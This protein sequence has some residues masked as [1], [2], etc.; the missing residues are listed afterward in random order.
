MADVRAV[1]E[2]RFAA[3]YETVPDWARARLKKGIAD[4]WS[5]LGAVAWKQEFKQTDYPA[6]AKVLQRR[7]PRDW[8]LVVARPDTGPG[9]I[10][11]AVLPPLLSAV[12]EVAVLWVGQEE[13]LQ[14]STLLA[15]ELAGVEQVYS[16]DQ[17]LLEQGMQETI[18]LLDGS[19]GGVLRLGTPP[20]SGHH[21]IP[22]PKG[23]RFWQFCLPVPE[24]AGI[25]AD[26][27]GLW[28][29]ETL[30]FAHPNLD[31]QVWSASG[32]PALG[33]WPGVQGGWEDFLNRDFDLVLVEEGKVMEALRHF[34]VVLGPG[35]EVSWIWPDYPWQVCFRDHL[36]WAQAAG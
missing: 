33:K 25:F 3:A 22:R 18:D 9:V 12:H 19:W 30:H 7:Q 14:D 24:T 17:R 27:P 35:Q 20:G 6:G 1:A 32:E 10:L 29:F 2:D 26:D 23:K 15:L 21:P 34:P 28:D 36:G 4:V 31:I 11:G 16:C 13:D 5:W 8:C